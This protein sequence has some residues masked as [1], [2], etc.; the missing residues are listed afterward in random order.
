MFSFQC[1]NVKVNKIKKLSS[2]AS[3]SC[4]W[5]RLKDSLVGV[6]IST[7]SDSL[8]WIGFIGLSIYY[9]SALMFCGADVGINGKSFVDLASDT[10]TTKSIGIK[11]TI[12]YSIVK[13]LAAKRLGL[14]RGRASMITLNSK[15]TFSYWTR[16]ILGQTRSK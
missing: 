7:S 12:V 16:N 6:Y 8:I 1:C 9:P 11:Q 5:Q 2:T 15:H 3:W 10:V 4:W 13:F 14:P